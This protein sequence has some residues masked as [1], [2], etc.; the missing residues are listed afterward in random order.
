MESAPDATQ[1]ALQGARAG[2]D[3][4]TPRPADPTKKALESAIKAAT[5]AEATE[6]EAKK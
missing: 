4:E 2:G 1:K 3:Q 6:A 5:E